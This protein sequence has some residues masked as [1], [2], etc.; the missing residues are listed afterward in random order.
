MV[1][2]SISAL[3]R[4]TPVDRHEL[5]ASLVYTVSNQSCLVRLHHTKQKFKVF[6]SRDRKKVYL[7]RCSCKIR[8]KEKCS[9]RVYLLACINE[10]GKCTLVL[11]LPGSTNVKLN[12]FYIHEN[13]GSD[14]SLYPETE[15]TLQSPKVKAERL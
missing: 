6:D 8:L 14:R 7:I 11:T 1:M 4:L 9:L 2:P 13:P 5:E 3:L 12:R 15:H 10:K